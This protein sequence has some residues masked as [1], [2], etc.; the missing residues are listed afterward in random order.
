MAALIAAGSS[1]LDIVAIFLPWL[2]GITS[3]YTPGRGL[4]YTVTLLLS[5]ID[6]FGTSPYLLLI[7]LP[8]SLTVVL[9]LL[10][11]RGE[12]IMPP[13]MKYQTKS[14]ILL[15]FAALFSMLPSL[16][17]VNSVMVGSYAV[18]DTGVFIGRWELGGAATM[19]LFAGFGFFL[20]LGL[21]IIKE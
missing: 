7:L 8:P 10:S 15:F 5:G 12:G 6:L 21:R 11:L 18:P 1:F 17:F 3:N 9:V 14:R 13:R 20:A 16:N 4:N 2:V 19:P